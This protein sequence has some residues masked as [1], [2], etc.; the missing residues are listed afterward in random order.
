MRLGPAKTA[1][2]VIRL[3]LE[4]EDRTR[5]EE[6][7]IQELAAGA[8]LEEL[9]GETFVGWPGTATRRAWIRDNRKRLEKLTE[10]IR[11]GDAP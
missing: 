9:A 2:T 4:T 5:E 7:A 11:G 3:A 10:Q 1:A 6:Q 8:A